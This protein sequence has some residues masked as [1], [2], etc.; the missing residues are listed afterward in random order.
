MPLDVTA[1]TVVARVSQVERAVEELVLIQSLQA[2]MPA[3]LEKLS[4]ST[5]ILLHG[6][7][8]IVRQT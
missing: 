2:E 5:G 4:H 1:A 3:R 8:A 6:S 7:P